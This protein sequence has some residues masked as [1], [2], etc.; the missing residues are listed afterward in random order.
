MV[1]STSDVTS[2]VVA[3]LGAEGLAGLRAE[4]GQGRGLPNVAYTSEDWLALERRH[5]MWPM[6]MLAGFESQIPD[7][8]E[9]LPVTVAGCPIVLV[10]RREGA[11]AAFHNVCRH[12]GAVIVPQA[13]K[14]LAT[15][16]CPYHAWAYGLDGKLRTRPHF[17]GGN[18]H[19]VLKD[20]DARG[21]LRAV[22]CESWR[23]MLFVNIDGNAPPLAEHMKPV[24]DHLEGWASQPLAY[25]G[26]L[27]FE[28]AANWKHIH[29]NFIDVYHKF[30][31]HPALCEFAPLQT[32]NP[33]VPIA[34]HLLKTWHV[35]AAPQE[36]RGKG[37]PPLPGLPDALHR[38]GRFFTMI[39]TCD[40][41]IW[42]DQVAILVAEP[43]G[44]HTTRETIHLLF[45]PEAMAGQFDA[46]RQAVLDT[47][48]GLNREDIAPLESMQRGRVSP[49]FD[50]GA[51]SPF[52]DPGTQY[53]ARQIAELMVQQCGDAA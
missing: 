4:V 27:T 15:L 42:Y 1:P 23:G 51:L 31:I 20:G 40:I 2:S 16:T 36:G 34:D 32:S 11:I 28:V 37:L 22:R 45:A 24:D 30:A 35:I 26:A 17:R 12:R 52:W 38:E 29:E 6:W 19:D 13:C 8:G 25:G 7:A 41:N 49:G 5:L 46:A 53:F 48:D 10:R 9:A 50:G 33:M 18:R 44:P 39:P 43:T 3:L 47:W 21:N 14:G